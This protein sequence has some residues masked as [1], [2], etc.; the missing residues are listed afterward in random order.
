MLSPPIGTHG[1]E[2]TVGE[3]VE[4][5]PRDKAVPARALLQVFLSPLHSIMATRKHSTPPFDSLSQPL[6]RAP[7]KDPDLLAKARGCQSSGSK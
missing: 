5:T 2:N 4:R 6:T 7:P 3:K 1:S